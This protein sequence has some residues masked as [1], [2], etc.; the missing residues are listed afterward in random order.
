MRFLIETYPRKIWRS[1]TNFDAMTGFW[2]SRHLEFRRGLG[3]LQTQTQNALDRLQDP[4]AARNRIR[5]L[6]HYFIE[7]LHGHH[8]IEDHHYFPLLIGAEPRL[9][10]GFDML[11]KDHHALTDH[12]DQLQTTARHMARPD[13]QPDFGGML[14]ILEPFEVF[15]DRHLVDE[16]DLIVP[17]ILEHGLEHGPVH[18]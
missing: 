4:D 10:R 15:L 12:L 1:H 18:D 11:D 13:T 8:Q 17:I 3:L 2:L 7:A 16:E 5:H 9:E 14:A 6:T